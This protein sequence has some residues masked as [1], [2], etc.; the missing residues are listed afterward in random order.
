MADARVAKPSDEMLTNAW[1]DAEQAVFQNRTLIGDIFSSIH[2]S[3]L[4]GQI[5]VPFARTPSAVATQIVNYTPIG[6]IATINKQIQKGEFKQRQF[7]RAMGRATIGTG[8][9][10]L[11]SQLFKKDMITLD[12]P[13]N[14][15]ERELWKLE[16]RKANSINM[17][18]VPI[19]GKVLGNKWRGVESLGPGGSVGYRSADAIASGSLPAL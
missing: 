2:K 5:I 13:D 10:F 11:G 9:L 19:I 16:G 4:T 12:Y 6:A 18:D 8:I 15:K 3:S 7:S 14:E 17:S 1:L